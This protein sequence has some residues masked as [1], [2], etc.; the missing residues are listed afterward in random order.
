MS[1]AKGSIGATIAQSVQQSFAQSVSW[2]R[3]TDS[4][5][6]TTT[7]PTDDP[8]NSDDQSSGGNNNGPST[9]G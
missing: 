6:D 8:T 4:D 2:K 5:D 3:V 7:D 1:Q 9:E